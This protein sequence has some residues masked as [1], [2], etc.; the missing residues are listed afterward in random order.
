MFANSGAECL[1][2]FPLY[3]DA[4][5]SYALAHAVLFN[6][7]SL[8]RLNADVNFFLEFS[9][10]RSSSTLAHS[11]VMQSPLA[12]HRMEAI[13]VCAKPM[14]PYH[15]MLN[16]RQCMSIPFAGVPSPPKGVCHRS[17]WWCPPSTASAIPSAFLS[18]SYARIHALSSCFYPSRTFQRYTKSW[19]LYCRVGVVR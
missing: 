2:A 6:N 11:S 17:C 3:T 12:H 16:N 15:N 5:I 10:R 1:Y 9:I 14:C 4:T 8:F 7:A 18:K 13:S 19:L